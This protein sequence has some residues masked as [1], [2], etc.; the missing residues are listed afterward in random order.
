MSKKKDTHVESR[1]VVSSRDRTVGLVVRYTIIAIA[2][3][4]ALFPVLFIVSSAFNPTGQLSTQSLVPR[5]VD[6]PEKLLT[7]F[8]ALMVDELAV[9][10]F[11]NWIA[12]SFFVASISTVLTVLIAAMSAYSF[13]RFRFYG[14]RSMLLG[15][16]LIQVFPNLLAIVSLF[17]I[18]QDIGRLAD[19]IPEAIPALSFINWH[20]LDRFSLDSLGGVILLYMAGAMGINTW[21]MKGFFDTIPREIDESAT[22]DGA[23]HWQ[24]FWILIFP[25]V[26]P[27]L[28]VV[29]ILAFVGTFNEFIIA[30]TILRD[31]E[32]WTLMVGLFNFINSDFNRD[33][34]KFAAGAL[35]SGTPVVILYLLLQDQIVGGLTS[36]A[37][38]G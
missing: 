8:R 24:T 14:R 21:L 13:S 1:M 29:G 2:I 37:V 22:V 10:P 15:I 23:T 38:K 30:R 36:G 9:Y 34:G 7:N 33:W 6:S 17:L 3:I 32:N 25:L 16:L 11:W 5:G 18:L 26:R 31:K 28:A 20:W 4:F 35:I 27:I 12:N 19:A